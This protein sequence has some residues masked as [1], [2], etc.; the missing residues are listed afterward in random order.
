MCSIM[1]FDI[2]SMPNVLLSGKYTGV[3]NPNVSIK[4]G[5]V[6]EAQLSTV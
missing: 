6:L 3:N 2:F 4:R 5:G 1:H